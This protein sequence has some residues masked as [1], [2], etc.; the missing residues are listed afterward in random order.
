MAVW[1]RGRHEKREFRNGSHRLRS[2]DI[3]GRE[4]SG[5]GLRR[6]L[7]IHYRKCFSR[8]RGGN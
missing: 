6:D 8:E 3:Y 2:I 1:W 5:M 7:A 4:K